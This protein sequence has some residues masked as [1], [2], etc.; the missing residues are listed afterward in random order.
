MP[1]HVLHEGKWGPYYVREESLGEHPELDPFDDDEVLEC[2]LD[3]VEVCES[4]Q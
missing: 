1:G 2:G 4:C 3:H